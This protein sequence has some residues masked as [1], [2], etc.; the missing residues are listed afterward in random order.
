VF[1]CYFT[2]AHRGASTFWEDKGRDCLAK[3]CWYLEKVSLGYWSGNKVVTDY[4]HGRLS[5]DMVSPKAEGTNSLMQHKSCA[6][7]YS[8]KELLSD[9]P[10]IDMFR[11][12][13][14]EIE[15]AREIEDIIQFVCRG[16]LRNPDAT[17]DYWVYLYDRHQ[18]EALAAYLTEHGLG[19]AELLPVEEAGLL[20]MRRLGPGRPPSGPEDS[21]SLEERLKQKQVKDAD[22]QR[23]KRSKD[24]AEEE[25]QGIYRNKPGRPTK[26][27]KVPPIIS[28]SPIT[29]SPSPGSPVQP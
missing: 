28:G 24:K 27:S 14:E 18:A 1:I 10:L 11:L 26:A 13:R 17:G 29:L 22:R 16:D 15:R 9:A 21:R 8:S 3:V 20:D 23:R 5:G 4:F 7:I 25:S 19:T 12:N 6:F 2:R